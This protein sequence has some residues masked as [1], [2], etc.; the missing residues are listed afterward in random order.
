MIVIVAPSILSL[1]RHKKN[2]A[3]TGLELKNLTQPKS[4]FGHAMPCYK[5]VTL[6]LIISAEGR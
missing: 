3:G 6:S 5:R 1:N 4:T 2:T